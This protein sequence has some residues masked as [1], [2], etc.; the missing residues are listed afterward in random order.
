MSEKNMEHNEGI[1]VTDESPSVEPR[2][3]ERGRC[4]ATAVAEVRDPFADDNAVA[5][6]YETY[7]STKDDY[8][9]ST[10][11]TWQYCADERFDPY[12]VA[13][14]GRNIFSAGMPRD[15]KSVYREIEGGRQLYIGRPER[16]ANWSALDNR[17]LLAHNASFDEVVTRECWKRGILKPLENVRWMCTADLSSY[18]MAP[19]NLKGAMEVLFGKVISKEVRS[20]MDGRHDWELSES[21]YRDLV[22]YGGS[23]A[24][25]CH[26]LWLAFAS[27]WPEVERR[28]SEQNR[29][30][31]IEG[32]HVDRTYAEKALAELVAYREKVMCDIPWTTKVNPKTGEF[33]KVGSLPALRQAVI[34]LGVTPPSTFKKDAPEFLDWLKDH[35]DIPFIRA[36]QTA[37]ALSMHSARIENTLATLDP[38]DNSHPAFL[39]FGAHSGRFSGKSDGAASSGNLLNMPRKPVFHG[40]PNV[41]NGEGVD[42]R[43]MYVPSDGYKFV[44]FDYSQIE[45]RF[46]LWL[47]DDRH[48]MAAMEREGNLYQA[49]A[50]AMGWCRSGDKIKKTNPDLYRLAKAA[51]L[52]LGYGMGAV[53]FV[54]ACKSQGIEM[55][56]A[57]VEEWPDFSRMGWLISMLRSSAGIHGDL[58]APEN[59]TKVGQIVKSLSIV[60][61]WRQANVK[62][63]SRWEKYATDFRL[64]AA[65]G[66]KTYAIML[67]SGRIKRYYDP[68][69]AKE[70]TVEVDE[71]GVQHPSTRLAMKATVVR[72]KPPVFLT[73]GK[74]MENVVQASCRDVMTWGCLEIT[75]RH[76]NWRFKFSVYDEVIFEVPEAECDEAKVEIPRIMC[77]GER[78]APWTQGLPLEVEGEVCDRY[79]K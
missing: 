55:Q 49:N 34:D 79:C 27:K 53:K 14:C 41:F 21:E 72:G 48:M 51:S 57:P 29:E 7:Y 54:D 25:E 36:R 35:D 12:L 28:I 23:D 67:P 78:I 44:I 32:I 3:C 75:E 33:Y 26:D 69:L 77:H 52:G 10:M 65:A 73:G 47:V 42:I 24:V 8:S 59:R 60:K 16:F 39:Y 45:A 40:D 17:L 1:G 5:I 43:G 63:V 71:N 74:I 9:L 15:P 61:A 19:R 20:A 11:P 2:F 50:V 31:T 30:A 76:P 70:P 66:K 13:I 22:E 18:L 37:V 46:S 6:D 58:F 68:V 64:R 62:I 56:S 38:D 4:P